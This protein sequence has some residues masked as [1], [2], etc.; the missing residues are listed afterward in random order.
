MSDTFNLAVKI[1]R[2]GGVIVYPTETF[3]GLGG[4]GTSSEVVKKIRSLKNRPLHKPFPLIAG[5]LKQALDFVSFNKDGL[6]LAQS[7]WPASLSIL[8][9]ASSLLV[10]GVRDKK[11]L[12][13]IRVPPHPETARLCLAAGAP[14]IATSANI[15]GEKP[16]AEKKELN[17]DLVRRAD[18]ILEM[19]QAPEGRLPSTL[20]RIAGPGRIEILREGRV[21]RNELERSGWTTV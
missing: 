19:N 21:S 7:F 16:C 3:W 9:G 8:A 6:E 18:M 4:L 11:G 2:S 10:E 17:P 5:N 15:S 20:V 14:L 12:V 1:I 13:S